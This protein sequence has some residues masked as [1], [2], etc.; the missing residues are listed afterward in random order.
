ME[1]LNKHS[2]GSA[3]DAYREWLIDRLLARAVKVTQDFRRLEL[4]YDLIPEKFR[5]IKD[6]PTKVLVPLYHE[7]VK[8]GDYD[9]ALRSLAEKHG[10]MFTYTPA[11]DGIDHINVYSKGNT[12]LGRSLTNFSNI[13]F[14]HPEYGTFASVEGFWYWLGTGKVHDEL[15]TLHGFEAKEVGRK[16]PKMEILNFEQE[17]KKAIFLKVEQCIPLREALKESKLPFTH[18]YYYGSQDNC[19]IITHDEAKWFVDY[20]EVVRR[21]VQ[22]TAHKVIIAGSRTITDYNEVLT[23]YKTSGFEAVIIVSGGARGVDLLGERVANELKIPIQRFIPDW[24]TEGKKAGML[25]NH[26]MGDYADVLVACYDGVSK[27]TKDMI[28][29]MTR[30]KKPIC[31]IN[32]LSKA[33]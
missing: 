14:N 15:R 17:I 7:L 32:P 25:R 4:S 19:K 28:D 2:D 22:G 8:S 10:K 13:P 23:A 27:G 12:K 3:M 9:Q 21:Y 30:L 16:L 11:T 24:D 29:Y 18:Y 33:T 20:L 1:L 26:A 31:L 6:I 5:S